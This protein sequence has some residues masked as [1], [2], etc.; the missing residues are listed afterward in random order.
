MINT[1]KHKDITWIDLENPTKG[2]V[3]EMIEKFGVDPIV[4]DE[5]LTPTARSRVDLHPKY[6]Y[7]ILHFPGKIDGH[8]YDGEL[9]KKTVEVD[10]II[11]RDF[12]ITTRYGAV[13]AILEFSKVFQAD[14]ILNKSNIGKHAGYI[15]YYMIRNIYKNMYQEIQNMR[16]KISDYETEVFND[17]ERAMVSTLSRMN[18]VLLYYKES[19][20]FHREILSSFEDA[21]KQIFEQE[22]TYYLRAVL[23]EYFKVQNAL[24]SAKDYLAELR[25]TNDS[26]LSSKQNEIMKILTVTNFVFLPLALIAGI[27]GMNTIANPI[28]GTQND[29][30]VVLSIMILLA[31]GMYI[32]FRN[33]KWL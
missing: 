3:R 18:R 22:F 12:I 24:E 13:D 29:F 30:F 4:A 11:G 7:L 8:K 32:F 26:L 20:S 27:F 28:V 9:K 5:L 10:F 17:N 19:L 1:F 14:S 23:G 31:L 2:E 16:D 25:E 21:G 33:K 15:F 6:I